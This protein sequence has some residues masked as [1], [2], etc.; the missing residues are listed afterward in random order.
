[1]EAQRTIV[2]GDCQKTVSFPSLLFDNAPRLGE[3]RKQLPQTRSAGLHNTNIRPGITRD[4]KRRRQECVL[5]AASAAAVVGICERSHLALARRSA[6]TTLQCPLSPHRG[7][8]LT[9]PLD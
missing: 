6:A 5:Y 3:K 4:G 9:Q 2:R 1:M 8:P 7:V